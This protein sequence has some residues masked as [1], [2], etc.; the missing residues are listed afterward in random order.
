MTPLSLII[1]ASLFIGIGAIQDQV[2]LWQQVLSIAV[3]VGDQ[4][5]S[6]RSRRR[7]TRAPCCGPAG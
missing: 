2:G 5:P 7:C 4:S 1:V 3:N 6:S